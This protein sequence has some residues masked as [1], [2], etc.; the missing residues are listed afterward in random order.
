MSERANLEREA[1]LSAWPGFVL[2]DLNDALPGLTI[3]EPSVHALDAVYHDAPDVRLGRAG[4]TLRHRSGEGGRS[5]RWT[6]KVPADPDT[7][8]ALMRRHELSRDAPA[9]TAPTALTRP[10]RALLRGAEL[11][12]LA[13]LRTSRRTVALVVG[14]R[15]VG[16][17]SDDEVAVLDGR[18]VSARFREIEIEL[19]ADAPVEVLDA[20]VARLRAAGAADPQSGSKLARA[21]GPRA[22]IPPDPLIPVVEPTSRTDVAVQAALASDVRRLMAFVPLVFVAPD[23]EVIH[24]A[25]VATRRLRSHLRTFSPVLQA[26]RRNSLADEL[27]WL[28]EAFGAVRDLDVFLARL[29]AHEPELHEDDLG[30][31][32]AMS[33]RLRDGREP[34]LARL[35]KALAADRAATLLDAAVAFAVEPPLAGDGARPAARVLPELARPAC[36]KLDRDARR[37]DDGSPVEALHA[38]RIRAKRARYAAE[39]AEAVVPAARRQAKALAALQDVLGDLHDTSITEARLRAAVASGSPDEA[40]VAGLVV[41]A[42]RH[43]ATVLRAAW[44]E[45]WRELR[46]RK[47]RAWLDVSD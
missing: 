25:R 34:V 43:R 6:L 32:R 36:D 19:A 37:L 39:A 46:R 23:V 12:P 24:Q 18:K 4:V 15:T 38:L 5:G 11:T 31:L 7:D 33:S 17:V 42:E 28:G 3:G 16:E 40:F 1:K 8:D 27:R 29:A 10:V 14:D 21:V 35:R 26:S 45:P 9:G 44:Q 30:V 2:P 47:V 41:A 13:R 22:Y 20:V